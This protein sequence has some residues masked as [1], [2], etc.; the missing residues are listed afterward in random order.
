MQISA[1]DVEQSLS[2]ISKKSSAIGIAL[3]AAVILWIS[4]Q[5]IICA[6]FLLAPYL[7]GTVEV[8]SGFAS[9]EN[10]VLYLMINAAFVMPIWMIAD[11]CK[12]TSQG[13]SPFRVIQVR[14]FRIASLCVLSVALLS[15]L[16]SAES[17]SVTFGGIV[18]GIVSE[19]TVNVSY[20]GTSA[21]LFL[22]SF[23]FEYG[24][25]LQNVSDDTV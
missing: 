10:T 23:V 7:G 8:S 16:I 17:P 18:G 15:P 20:F 25:L 4:T 13:L 1:K 5:A 19:P 14:R 2:R 22:L 24:V 12:E 21:V 3:K 6:L 11:V 9:I